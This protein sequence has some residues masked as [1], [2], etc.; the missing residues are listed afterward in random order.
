MSQKKSTPHLRE[1]EVIS[2]SANAPHQV[3]TTR[4]AADASVLGRARRCGNGGGG[5]LHRRE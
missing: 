4:A 1:G 3:T 2:L 5:G